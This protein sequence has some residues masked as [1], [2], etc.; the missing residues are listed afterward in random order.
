M[1]LQ[2]VQTIDTNRLLNLAT[3]C[4]EN[5][6]KKTKNCD[7]NMYRLWTKT[8][9]QKWPQHLQRMDKIRLRKVATTCTKYGKKQ[10]TKSGYFLYRVCTQTD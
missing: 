6:H 1:W 7:Y 5:G 2:L 8:D 4:T 9:Y 10:T 3:T